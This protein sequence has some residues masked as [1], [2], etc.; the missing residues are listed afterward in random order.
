MAKGRI[1][2]SALTLCVVIAAAMC[3]GGCAGESPIGPS[4]SAAGIWR[5]SVLGRTSSPYYELLL[6]QSGNLIVGLAC[7]GY[8]GG[9]PP[10]ALA[11]VIITSLY[12]N[13]RFVHRYTVELP[14]REPTNVVIEFSGKFEADRDQIAGNYGSTP[15]RFNRFGEARCAGL[16]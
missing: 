8:S 11:G 14:G 7:G 5:A 13:V 10:S 12:P 15:L 4:K 1:A 3:G 2:H 6:T 9:P 16:L